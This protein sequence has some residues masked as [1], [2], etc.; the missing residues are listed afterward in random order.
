MSEIA[1]IN[2][3]APRG[4]K[5][6]TPPK[7]PSLDEALSGPSEREQGEIARLVEAIKKKRTPPKQ[8]NQTA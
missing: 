6:P 3:D 7:K 2:T 1:G 8:V 4:T 5:R